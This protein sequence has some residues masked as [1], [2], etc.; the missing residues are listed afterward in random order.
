MTSGLRTGCMLPPSMAFR[1]KDKQ[2]ISYGHI[3]GSPLSSSRVLRHP[4]NPTFFL[5]KSAQ[6]RFFT[7][8]RKSNT[9][10]VPAI[11]KRVSG[12]LGM[13]TL[14]SPFGKG[15]LRGISLGFKSPLAPLCE[16]GVRMLHYY[17]ALHRRT[18]GRLCP[19]GHSLMQ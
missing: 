16:R 13:L 15:G 10:E 7:E 9:T 3:P 5:P 14:T 19:T 6:N 2:D 18:C 1:D 4:R 17:V 12:H 11:L 8:D